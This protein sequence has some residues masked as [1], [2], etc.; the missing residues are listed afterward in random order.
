M[1]G[2]KISLLIV[3]LAVG[4]LINLQ[5]Q[6]AMARPGGGHG[7]GGHGG[8]AHFSG[9]GAHFSGHARGVSA[10]RM[11]TSG[12]GRAHVRNVSTRVGASRIGRAHTGAANI[13]GTRLGK[14]QAGTARTNAA[15]ANISGT[16]LGKSQ[17]GIARTNA[18]QARAM[19]ATGALGAK[20]AWNQWGNPNWQS[21][22][23]GGWGGWN[24][25]WGG[26][27]GGWG[28][29]VGPVFWPYFFGNLVAFT[30]W[31][32]PYFYP[33]WGYGD[34]FVWD[35]IFWPGPYYA[36]GPAYAYG[37][38]HYDVYGGYAYE[39]P[40]R[41]RTARR[42]GPEITGS[43]PNKTDLA[44]SC[45]GL[46]PGVTDFPVDRIKTTMSLT[47]E[48]L[49][50]LD[51]LKAASSQASDM[52]KS[53]CA[54]NVPLTPLARLEM[55]QKRI[56]DTMQALQTV[57]APLDNFYNSLN[58]DQRQRF[59]ALG[60]APAASRRGVSSDN[61]LAALCSR[62][63]EGFTQLPVQRIEQ[64]IKPIQ[65]Q[66]DAFDRL[67]IASAEAANQLQASCPTQTPQTPLDRFDAVAKRLQAMDDAIKTVSPAL[68]S[69][70]ASLTDE[71][72]ARFNTLGPPKNG[73]IR[74]G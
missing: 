68:A 43:I 28:G 7:G 37:P 9:G 70:Y 59:A 4:A 71:Q 3:A 38:D 39:G 29:W 67:R 13:S 10:A 23:K 73:S 12:I 48:Q 52:L 49:T 15:A 47:D 5:T 33:F 66:L 26:W 58:D 21:G 22:S 31:P 6:F 8:G 56:D 60:P 30:F 61:D 54:S 2:K 36:Y 17:A 45:G 51:A 55:V 16:G 72:K 24:G 19:G 63:A 32:Y 11:G 41:R 20:A 25:G 14:S 50:A 44:Q 27:N 40:A 64:A 53:S 62:R 35:A 74:Q 46:A 57:R 65:Q 42:V 18:A 69:F 1:T 34:L